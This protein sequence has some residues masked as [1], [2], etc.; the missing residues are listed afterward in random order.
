MLQSLIGTGHAG[1]DL[2]L[3]TLW[4]REAE[5]RRRMARTRDWKYVTDPGGGD[6][7][8]LYDLRADPWEHVNRAS[9]PEYAEIVS[10]MRGLLLEMATD[11]EDAA[12]VPLPTSVGRRAYV[13]PDALT[14]AESGSA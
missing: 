14:N 11:T 9:N 5:G 13:P 7:D 12:P 2:I 3:N 10:Q 8:E 4:I 1:R 6:W